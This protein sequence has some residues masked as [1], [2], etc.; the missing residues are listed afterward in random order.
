M[1]LLIV[2]VQHEQS[3]YIL[4]VGKILCTSEAIDLEIEKDKIQSLLS[5]T[6][7]ETEAFG[8]EIKALF[9]E[10]LEKIGTSRFHNKASRK[11][12]GAWSGHING[13]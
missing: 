13:A 4:R 1:N 7:E 12:I 5:N 10:L 9:V 11:R 3:I 6:I 2:E 8:H